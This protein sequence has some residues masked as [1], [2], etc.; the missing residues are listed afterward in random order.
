MSFSYSECNNIFETLLFILFVISLL[1]FL[2]SALVIFTNR[3]L[4]KGDSFTQS[5]LQTWLWPVRPFYSSKG[6]AETDEQWRYIYMFS[7]LILLLS[8]SILYFTGGC[9]VFA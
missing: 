1:V 7:F 2:I 6:V 5:I 8:I 9:G 3:D 4:G